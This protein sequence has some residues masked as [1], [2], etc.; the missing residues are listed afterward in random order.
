MSDR[1]RRDRNW[2]PLNEPAPPTPDP[3][4]SI[5]DPVVESTEEAE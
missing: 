2:K 1:G 5:E 3:E 4:P